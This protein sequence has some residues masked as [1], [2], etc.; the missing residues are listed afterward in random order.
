MST[1]ALTLADFQAQLA[2]SDKIEDAQVRPYIQFAYTLDLL[3]LF[4]YATIEAI[5]A[6]PSAAIAPYVAGAPVADDSSVLYRERVYRATTA[7]PATL[8]GQDTNWV[9]EPLR[10]LW[11]QYLKPWWVQTSYVRFAAEHGLN[12]TKA[13]IT[14]P[15]DRNQGTYERPTA[16]QKAELMAG[17]ESTAGAYYSRLTRFLHQESAAHRKDTTTGY[18]YYPATTCPARPTA[19]ST[20]LR[21]INSPRR[22]H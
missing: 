2:F 17:I 1:L 8:P 13:G 7:N 6:L 14:V 16:A 18:A 5:D 11:T 20:R 15:V 10:T 9:Y 12:F 22:R 3:P 19:H 4:E 21:G